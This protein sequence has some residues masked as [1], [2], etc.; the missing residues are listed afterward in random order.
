MNDP[1]VWITKN[2][3]IIPISKL[4]N[5]HL[6][7]IVLMLFCQ[8]PEIR[9]KVIIDVQALESSF[10]HAVQ[11][12]K[13]CQPLDILMQ[14]PRYANV[15]NEVKRRHN[16]LSFGMLRQLRDATGVEW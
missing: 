7:N 5:L 8:V 1:T 16:H 13:D 14:T 15:I 11:Q 3:H 4:S 2:E 12:L 6:M 9:A 10:P